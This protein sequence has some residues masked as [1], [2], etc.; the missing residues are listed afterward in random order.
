MGTKQRTAQA[1]LEEI[2]PAIEEVRTVARSARDGG[3]WVPPSS[4]LRFDPT[5]ANHGGH[6]VG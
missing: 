4:A 5:P 1:V 2:N 6:C 3:T